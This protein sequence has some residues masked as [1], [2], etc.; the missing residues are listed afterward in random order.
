MG[1]GG[2][3][4]DSQLDS[5]VAC[6]RSIAH[7]SI[8]LYRIPFP[9]PRPWIAG[10][11]SSDNQDILSQNFCFSKETAAGSEPRIKVCFASVSTAGFVRA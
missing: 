11:R 3:S 7:I 5:E 10:D 8:V 6:A 2:F 9:S 1:Y 4:P